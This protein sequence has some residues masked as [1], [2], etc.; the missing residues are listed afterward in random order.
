MILLKRKNLLFFFSFFLRFLNIYTQPKDNNLNEVIPN[1]L[2]KREKNINNDNSQIK[3]KEICLIEENN[4][5]KIK[6][7]VYNIYFN[8]LIFI[9]ILFLIILISF[10][11]YKICSIL[12]KENSEEDKNNDE[13]LL[14]YIEKSN[15]NDKEL[16]NDKEKIYDKNQDEDNSFMNGELLNNSGLEAPPVLQI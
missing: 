5:L 10:I 4:K 1:N 8:F 15:N 13:I 7:E 3:E 6:I 16:L 11:I 2:N 9:N 12:K 14:N